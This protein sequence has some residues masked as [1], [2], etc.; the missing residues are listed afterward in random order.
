MNI[1]PKET[2]NSVLVK[3]GKAITKFIWFK[4]TR[5]IIGVCIFI[6]SANSYSQID[7][8]FIS[9]V[10]GITNVTLTGVTNGQI[11]EVSTP[12]DY[13]AISFGV[14]GSWEYSWVNRTGEDRIIELEGS[15]SVDGPDQLFLV[16][17]LASFTAPSNPADTASNPN[18][19][20]GTFA[21]SIGVNQFSVGNYLASVIAGQGE[22]IEGSHVEFT[23]QV[24]P[25]P[26]TYA[27]MLAGLGLVLWR[28]HHVRKHAAFDLE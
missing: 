14:S 2:G 24:V 22:V 21:H 3:A 9:S 5:A 16:Q 13:A 20:S 7:G 18:R 4:K 11:F 8:T 15:Y 17:T 26:E 1:I 25:E 6:Y 27:L 12:E 23:V 10:N 19:G 28:L